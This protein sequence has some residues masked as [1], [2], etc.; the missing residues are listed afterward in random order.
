MNVS[1]NETG[2]I[3]GGTNTFTRFGESLNGYLNKGKQ[4]LATA[5]I[6]TTGDA[7]SSTAAASAS[8]QPPV[9][10]PAAP[11]AAGGGSSGA[12]AAVKAPRVFA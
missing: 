1:N 12:T 3:A 5:A 7:D 8:A 2:V 4:K 9:P 10:N 6:G 11:A